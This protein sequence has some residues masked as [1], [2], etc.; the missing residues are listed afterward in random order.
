LF[1][2]LVRDAQFRGYT[3]SET[4]AR[5]PKVRQG[6]D[7]HIFPFQSHADIFFNSGLTYEL[8]VLKLWAEPRLAAVDSDDPHYGLAR[9][10]IELLSLLL[11]IDASQVPPTSLLREFIG[12][13]GFHY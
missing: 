6:E 2:R 13:S 10:L 12:G 7:K 1:R 11:P 8:A 5:W 3:A 4:L 9:T